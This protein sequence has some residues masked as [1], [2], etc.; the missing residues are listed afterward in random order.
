MGTRVSQFVTAQKQYSTGCCSAIDLYVFTN[1]EVKDVVV[2]ANGYKVRLSPAAKE[3]IQQRY[4][5]TPSESGSQGTLLS[6]A[7]VT[8]VFCAMLAAFVVATFCDCTF[9]GCKL[10]DCQ[11]DCQ[12]DNLPYV[13]MAVYDEIWFANKSG[14]SKCSG[15][16]GQL[17]NL[18]VVPLC[19]SKIMQDTVAIL[20][21][22]VQPEDP[23]TGQQLQV[24]NMA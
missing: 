18:L 23:Q 9:C 1:A 15:C 5:G 8:V 20:P 19:L 10:C 4:K 24:Q 12:C 2:T 22:E 16:L 17:A 7:V 11:C 21:N 14:E 6:F 13:R 3:K